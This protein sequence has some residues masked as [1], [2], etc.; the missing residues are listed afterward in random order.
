MTTNRQP[1]EEAYRGSPDF[2][3]TLNLCRDKWLGW[4]ILTSLGPSHRFCLGLAA[5]VAV[6]GA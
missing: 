6:T 4:Y 2:T 3:A 1:Q 5:D